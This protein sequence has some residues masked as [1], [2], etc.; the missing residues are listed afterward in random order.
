M[1]RIYYEKIMIMNISFTSASCYIQT[2]L[3]VI[4]ISMNYNK[5]AIKSFFSEWIM[6]NLNPG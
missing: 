3:L 2:G 4:I 5:L 6:R 1:L